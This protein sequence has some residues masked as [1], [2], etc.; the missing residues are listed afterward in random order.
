MKQQKSYLKLLW[1]LFRKLPDP[2][3]LVLGIAI[4]LVGLY[5]DKHTLTTLPWFVPLGFTFPGFVSSDYFPL[6]PHLGFFLMGAVMG[7]NL[8]RD[9]QTLLPKVNADHVLIR[10]LSFCGRQSLWI[11]LGHQPVLSGICILI[12]ALK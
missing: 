10:F 3:L 11:Y 8:Y 2:A 5:L 9:R 4:A 1:S 7:R 12:A 6:L